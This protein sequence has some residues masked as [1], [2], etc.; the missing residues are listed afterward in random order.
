[1]TPHPFMSVAVAEF[2]GTTAHLSIAQTGAYVRL[3]N[4]AWLT[5]GCSLPI[6]HDWI[7]TKVIAD[8]S[9]Y[10]RLVRP[11]LNE[12]FKP[13]KG[14]LVYPGLKKKYQEV[15]EKRSARAEAGKKG[16]IAKARKTNENEASNARVLLQQLES[17]L[18]LEKKESPLP[19]KGAVQLELIASDEIAANQVEAAFSI[20]NEMAARC[21]L[22]LAEDLT[23]G[24]RKAIGKR[25]E[26][27]GLER[28]RRAITAVEIS[29]HCRGENDRHWKASLDF[30]AQVSS[31][32]KLIE[33][34]Y[35]T[36]AKHGR[37]ALPEREKDPLDIWRRRMRE[38]T[39]NEWWPGDWGPKPGRI[40]CEV[41][42]P[43]LRESGYEPAALA[44][45]EERQAS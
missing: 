33:G 32:Q 29:P 19:P 11:V 39:T 6:D 24:R 10:D 44:A 14:R 2:G 8:A 43:V 45:V 22:P 21:D 9:T 4:L 28:W 16:G 26:G 35:G 42:A 18:E 34:V 31:F 38:W 41:P 25:L 15:T 5:P 1:M 13:I 20:W 17:E 12:F 23:D 30:V 36:G 7:R 37:A 27:G 3:I 40:G